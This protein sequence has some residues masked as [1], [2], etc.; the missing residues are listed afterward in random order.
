[1][2][3]DDSTFYQGRTLDAKSDPPDIR[4]RYYEPSLLQ[5][6]QQ[7]PASDGDAFP[8]LQHLNIRNQGSEGACTG[9]GLAAIVDYLNALRG[10]S[11]IKASPRMLYEMAKRH[12][13]WPGENYEGSSLRG[14]LRGFHNNGVCEES[15]WPYRPRSRDRRLTIKRAKNAW[16]TTLGAYYRLRPILTDFHAA[17]NEVEAIYVSA[18]VHDG[19]FRNHHGKIPL[20]KN[21][22]GG[23]AFTIIGYNDVGFWI[24][25]SWGETWGHNG[26]ALWRYEDWSDNLKDA[27]VFRLAVPTPQIYDVRLR[28]LAAYQ[29]SM[30]AETQPVQSVG[31]SEITGHFAHID[32]GKFVTNGDYWSDADYVKETAQR[33]STST[34]YQHVMFYAHG[35]LNSTTVSAR[36]VRALKEVYK[37]NGI[38]PYHFMWDSGLGEELKDVVVRAFKSSEDRAAGFF[39]FTDRIIET[40]AG[41]PGTAIWEEMKRDADI[42]F[43]PRGDGRT[44]MKLYAAALKAA[45][46]GHSIHLVGHSTGAIM[47]GH[48]LQA[49]DQIRRTHPLKIASCHLM[50]PACT[51]DFYNTH[52]ANRLGNV[53]GVTRLPKLTIYNLTD[54]REQDDSVGTVY[55]KSLLYL[56]SNAFERQRGRPLLGMEK[57]SSTLRSR[58]GLDIVYAGG[59]G[60]R[61]DSHS[62]SGFDNDVSTMNDILKGILGAPAKR[63]FKKE[64]MKGY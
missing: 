3:D 47:F 16:G 41:K 58:N 17:L 27:W 63:K 25:N 45:A 37:E 64:D 40:V 55:R 30:G 44:V 29:S 12:D 11:Q 48:L 24:Q 5:L 57:F 61:S 51:I 18:N 42:A 9:F 15:V 54:K 62:H 39:D 46:A 43:R 14:A 22:Q 34:K 59:S 36:R 26:I 7:Q 4:D 1:M 10:R 2:S 8:S 13:R 6:K 49:L 38:Y 33:V 31:R 23:H 50:A 52:Y 20:G 56:V 28:P 60:K 32:D 21:P 53:S 35:G 19:W